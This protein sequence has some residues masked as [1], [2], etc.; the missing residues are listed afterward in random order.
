MVR[1]RN[2]F[3]LFLAVRKGCD[4][5]IIAFVRVKRKSALDQRPWFRS[6]RDGWRT[7]ATRLGDFKFFLFFSSFG[8]IPSMGRTRTTNTRTRHLKAASSQATSSAATPP[9][10]P[11]LLAKAQSLIEQCNYQLAARFL[12]RILETDATH[13]EARELLGVVQLELGDLDA[14]RLVGTQKKIDHELKK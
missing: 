10:V 7:K 3:L 2:D 13:I 14:A 8:K 5:P 9:S 1:N 12:Q 6:R 11:D 4:L